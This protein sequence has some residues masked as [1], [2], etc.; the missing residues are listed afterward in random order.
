MATLRG[1][2][3][4]GLE[5][6]RLGQD[7]PGEVVDL[8]DRAEQI[9]FELGQQRVTSDFS[10]IEVLL[11]ESFER[12]T[13]LYEAGVDVTGVPSGFRELDSL[14]AGFQPGQ[15]RHPRGAPVHGEVVARARR[16]RRTS[17]CGTRR[18]SPSS[19]SRCRR[20]R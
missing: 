19:R 6:T 9:V 4:A 2:V 11:K 14:T 20:P 13:Q 8:V 12:I 15:P 7:R 3:R 17:R 1:L 10:H 18:P 16:R 5:I